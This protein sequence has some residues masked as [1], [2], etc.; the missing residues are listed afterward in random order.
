MKL[1]N[2]INK[3]I[4]KIESKLDCGFD[5]L[6]CPPQKFLLRYLN[7]LD[8][9]NAVFALRTELIAQ[10]NSKLYFYFS[11]VNDPVFL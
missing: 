1:I 5:I 8:P 6:S 11:L 9:D 4:K 10:V 7:Y 2:E 3:A